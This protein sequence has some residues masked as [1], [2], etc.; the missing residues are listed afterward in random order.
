M[1]KLSDQRRDRKVNTKKFKADEK[2]G[3]ISPFSEYVNDNNRTNYQKCDKAILNRMKF[4]LAEVKWKYISVVRI[5]KI[6]V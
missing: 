3:A 4:K 6:G 2:I 1:S 5:L